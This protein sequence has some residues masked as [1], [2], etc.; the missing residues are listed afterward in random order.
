MRRARYA[1]TQSAAARTL[2]QSLTDGELDRDSAAYGAYRRAKFSAERSQMAAR[3][4]DHDAAAQAALDAKNDMNQAARLTKATARDKAKRL[5]RDKKANQD[6]DQALSTVNPKYAK[7]GYNYTHNCSNVVQA[8]EL[9]RRGLDVQA[10][11]RTGIPLSVMETTWGGKYAVARKA[12]DHGKAEVEEAFKEHGSRGIVYVA[13]NSGGAHV[14]NV[15]NVGG[16]VRFVDGQPTP[17]E[18]DAS[19]YFAGSKDC[20]YMRVDDK[21]TPDR[22]V[23]ARYLES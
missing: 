22:S 17:H 1:V 11:P 12:A 13:W 10:G 19:H 7:G 8:H 6:I 4:G 23:L 5:A 15:E 3:Q 18:T 14:F 2:N 9:Q 20:R 16:Q 21:P